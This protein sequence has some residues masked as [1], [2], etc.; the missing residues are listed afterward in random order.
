MSMKQMISLIPCLA[1]IS[2]I[3][4]QNSRDSVQTIALKEITIN[5][6]QNWLSEITQA[7][8]ISRPVLSSQD[9]LQ[10]IPGLWIGQHAGGEKQNSC[11]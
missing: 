5:A 6:Q 11:F 2:Q 10:T 4:A 3:W 7:A 1:L 9:L 8:F